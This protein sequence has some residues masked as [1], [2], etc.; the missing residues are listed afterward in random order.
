[1]EGALHLGAVDLGGA[2]YARQR[3]AVGATWRAAL[4]GGHRRAHGSEWSR[5]T[6]HGAPPQSLVPVQ[7]RTGRRPPQ[8]PRQEPQ[9]RPGVRAIQRARSLPQPD[10]PLTLDLQLS[11][12]VHAARGWRV[13][14]DASL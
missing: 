3:V 13:K 14:L 11:S 7:D 10:S 9:G 4:V 5:R 12:S 8:D 6:L 2:L 1:Q